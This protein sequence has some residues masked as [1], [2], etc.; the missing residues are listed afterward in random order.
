MVVKETADRDNWCSES[1]WTHGMVVEEGI[2]WRRV[3]CLCV[4]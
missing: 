3:V 1:W 2:G 4:Y